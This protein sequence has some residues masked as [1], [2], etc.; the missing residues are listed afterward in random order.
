MQRS[1]HNTF[2][3]GSDK[4]KHFEIHVALWL[5]SAA[6]SNTVT[7]DKVELLSTL[8]VLASYSS[9]KS[10]KVKSHTS[11][12]GLD[13]TYHK[14]LHYVPSHKKVLKDQLH[15]KKKKK[16]LQSKNSHVKRL[17]AFHI[18]HT[19]STGGLRPL[20]NSV[21]CIFGLCVPPQLLM[22]MHLYMHGSVWVCQELNTNYSSHLRRAVYL[23]FVSSHYFPI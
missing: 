7:M 12:T 20:L 4:W 22:C 23:C 5:S 2:K 1:A 6:L 17:M 11:V 14:A 13:V 21:L 10:C 16:K 15:L 18:F 3:S 19:Y 8:Q 9:I